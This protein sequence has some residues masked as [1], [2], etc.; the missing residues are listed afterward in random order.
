MRLFL[1]HDF[2]LLYLTNVA[3]FCAQTLSRLSALQWLY[4]STNDARALGALGIVTLCVQLPSIALGGVLAD[5]L[6][7]AR[8]VSRVQTIA[9]CVASIRVLLSA[10]GTLTPS[11]IYI[12]VG[13]LEATKFLENS[14]RA[15]ILPAVVEPSSLPK[16]VSIVVL[17]Q[18]Y[19]PAC[20]CAAHAVPTTR[21]CGV[22]AKSAWEKV[23][24]LP[25]AEVQWL[26]ARTEHGGNICSVSVLVACRHRQN[27][28][29]LVLCCHVQFCCGR[30]AATVDLC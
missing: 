23:L 19:D 6:P 27:S 29:T 18:V 12:T 14:A 11:V 28:H 20:K 26:R 7:R 25:F 5:A 22:H 21:L 4:E 17:T 3:E 1:E 24:L 9:A 16:A 2:A 30:C 8:L 10:T 15:S 13:C